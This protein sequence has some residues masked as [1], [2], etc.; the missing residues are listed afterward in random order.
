MDNY[1]IEGHKLRYHVSRVNDWL[2]NKDIDPVYMEISP[3][4]FCNLRCIFC[5]YDYL[6]YEKKFLAA[7]VILKI[8]FELTRC[9]VKSVHFS[10]QGEPLLHKD[11]ARIVTHSKAVGLDVAMT[12]NGITLNDSAIEQILGSLVW[13]R[14]SVNAGTVSTYKYIHCTSEDTFN[15]VLKNIKQAVAIKKRKKFSCTIGIQCLL[16]PENI[17]EIKDLVLIARDIAVDYIC[18]KPYSRHRSSLNKIDESFYVAE[19]FTKLISEIEELATEDFAVIFRSHSLQKLK[20]PRPYDSCLALSFYGEI[21]ADGKIYTCSNFIGNPDFC[22]GSIYEESFAEIWHGPR[23][24]KILSAIQKD[25]D[26]NKMC[27]KNC[28]M[29]EINCYLWDL[30]HPGP[31]ANFI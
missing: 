5:A 2:Q 3:T 31:H 24:K 17:L 25:L 20:A 15:L 1:A 9:G 7:E 30:K 10:G 12:T 8:L 27:R 21:A 14:F 23:R 6:K 13:L 19:D 4:D 11:I 26:I 18:I 16:L 22:Y 29:E 28:R